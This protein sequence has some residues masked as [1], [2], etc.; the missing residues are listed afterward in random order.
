MGQYYRPVIKAEN[1]AD[2]RILDL[3]CVGEEWN[4]SKLLEHSYIHNSF[5]D[6]IT[7][8]L[9]DNPHHVVW[10][11]DYSDEPDDWANIDWTNY[12]EVWDVDTDRKEKLE[13]VEKFSYKGLKLINHTQKMYVSFYDVIRHCKDKYGYI[14]HPLSLLTALGNGRGGGDYYDECPDAEMC[15]R[16]AGDL[17]SVSKT[18]PAGYEQD[19]VRFIENM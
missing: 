11:G 18:V 12:A 5:M 6:A 16:W 13:M 19:F 4:G 3:K 15:G 1:D 14:I 9:I 7:N 17:I 8:L 10:A 2:V